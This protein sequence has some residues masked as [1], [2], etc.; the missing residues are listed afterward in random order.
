MHNSWF[1]AS[2]EIIFQTV[3]KSFTYTPFNVKHNV[4]SLKWINHKNELTIA[5]K[6]ER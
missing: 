6:D 1:Q 5:T 2:T 3:L 4:F